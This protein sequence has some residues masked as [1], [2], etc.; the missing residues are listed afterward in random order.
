MRFE[1]REGLWYVTDLETVNVRVPDAGAV[2][3]VPGDIPAAGVVVARPIGVGEL[4]PASAIGSVDG[5]R[6]TSVVLSAGGQ[7][8]ASIDAG[9]LVDVWASRE[10][11]S[12]DF[13][14]SSV[15]VAG[16]TVVR[17]VETESII[18]G[19]E[20]TAVEVLVPKTKVA[21]VLAA[22]ANSDAISIVAATLPGRR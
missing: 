19:G 22:I 18:A 12:G 16:A 6:L 2:Y 7:L 20:V 17:L 13:G 11:G 10:V 8:G 1:L 21:R 9:S 4:V 5:L 3:L 14:P 15:I